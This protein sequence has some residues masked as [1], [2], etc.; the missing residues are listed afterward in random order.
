MY[1]ELI[2]SI[3]LPVQYCTVYCTKYSYNL[4]CFYKLQITKCKYK[5]ILCSK[6]IL[7]YVLIHV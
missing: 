6:N 4:L 3:N 2:T 7:D 1:L 5:Y